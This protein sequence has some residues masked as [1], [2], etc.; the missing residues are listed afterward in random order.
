V[1][2]YR[3]GLVL[4]YVDE[5]LSVVWLDIDIELEGEVR[6]CNATQSGDGRD[7]RTSSERLLEVAPSCR[8][9]RF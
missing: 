2:G 9:F 5:V 8:G 7:G 1:D 3:H 6:R 4:F